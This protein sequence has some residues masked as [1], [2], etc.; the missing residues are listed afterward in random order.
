MA[1]KM[2]DNLEMQ[3]VT[4]QDLIRTPPSRFSNQE[5]HRQYQENQEHPAQ[6]QDNSHIPERGNHSSVGAGHHQQEATTEAYPPNMKR[7]E[8]KVFR[9]ADLEMESQ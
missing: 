6:D 8:S 1:Q 5:N 7:K 9:Q 3:R 4:M 2:Q